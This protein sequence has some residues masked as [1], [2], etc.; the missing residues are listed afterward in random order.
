MREASRKVTI[1]LFPGP[2]PLEG[3]WKW[4]VRH[5]SQLT[6]AV[7]VDEDDWQELSSAA[8]PSMEVRS[9]VFIGCF[10]LRWFWFRGRLPFMN[11]Q[12]RAA[13]NP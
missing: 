8:R 11:D 13:W 5:L 9:S 2:Y 7:G 1:P 10:R 4:M 6:A 3:A 12:H